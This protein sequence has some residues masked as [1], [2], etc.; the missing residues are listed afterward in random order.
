MLYLRQLL[1]GNDFALVNPAA[2]QMMNFAYLVGDR[3]TKECVVVDPAWDVRG[4]LGLAAEDGMKVTGVVATH[5]HPDHVGGNLFGLGIEGAAV[6]VELSKV[7]VWVH[8]LDAPRL[9]QVTGLSP[10]DLVGVMDG[11]SLPVGG[12]V[13]EFIH[14]P[15]HTPG[16]M[17]LRVGDGLITGDT[18]FVGACGRVDLP[19][20][21]P[22]DMFASLQKLAALPDELVVYPGH[23]YGGARTSTMGEEKRT[24]PYLR[25]R[26][27]EEWRGLQGE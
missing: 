25:V 4:L 16:S 2:A 21:N 22:D 15:G 14:T 12:T 26:T 11:G 6:L 8:E 7:K 10:D 13:I 1:S 24:N 17:C 18:L 5:N 3:D 27:L 23:H 20:S 19:G 9:A